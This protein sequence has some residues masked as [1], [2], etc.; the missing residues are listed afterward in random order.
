[1]E[2]K[3]IVFT[4]DLN[5]CA[6]FGFESLACFYFMSFWAV[7]THFGLVIKPCKFCFWHSV[8]DAMSRSILHST[9]SYIFLNSVASLKL[10][11]ERV[12]PEGLLYYLQ[13]CFKRQGCHSTSYEQILD[14][15]SD[16]NFPKFLAT[17]IF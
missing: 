6:N 15:L 2:S 11:L 1:M 7:P 14:S 16:S 5:V 17:R 12:V 3:I 10:T 8:L 13:P 4:W 9:Y